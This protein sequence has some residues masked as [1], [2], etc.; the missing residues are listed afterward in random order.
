LAINF[1]DADSELTTTIALSGLSAA[2]REIINDRKTD[3]QRN[4]KNMS[5]R[6]FDL[7]NDSVFIIL[8]VP[9]F[10]EQAEEADPVEPRD[11]FTD[12]IST[13]FKRNTLP[14]DL[15]SQ[16]RPNAFPV[17]PAT[18]SGIGPADCQQVERFKRLR[19]TL[20][21]RIENG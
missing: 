18:P 6:R 10:C 15:V 4:R 2:E 5:D 20:P 13:V 16:A 7:D 19:S 14:N 21:A 17:R 3:A 8:I 9:A 1:D 12:S 11:D